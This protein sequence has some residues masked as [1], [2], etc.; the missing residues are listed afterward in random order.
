MEEASRHVMV[1]FW[2][3]ELRGGNVYGSDGASLLRFRWSLAQ[4]R[5]HGFMAAK[6][7]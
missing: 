7:L 2:P 3:D 5:W 6:A 4:T 1:V